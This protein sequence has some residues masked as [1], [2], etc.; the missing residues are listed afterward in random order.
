MT[1]RIRISALVLILASGPSPALAQ[2]RSFDVAS[3]K[4]NRS[5]ELMVR[6]DTEPGGRFVAVN[7][8]LRMLIQLAYGLNDFDIGGAPSWVASDHFDITAVTVQELPP[9]EGPTQGSLALQELLRSLLRDRFALVA[10]TEERERDGLALT[11]A[12]ADRRLGPRLKAS[13]TDCAAAMAANGGP[14]GCGL[15]MGPGQ[16]TLDGVPLAQRAQ[17]LTQMRGRPV[18]DR[19]NLGGP[20]DLQLKWDPPV[21]GGTPRP[22]AMSLTTALGD[23]AGLRLAS[24][25][26][27]GKVLIIDSVQQPTAN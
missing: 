21:P 18:V 15:Q 24:I 19:T 8:T 4:P 11:L 14:A 5:G 26:V 7:A 25:R 23:Q 12:N 16:I 2:Q 20:F 3:V 22:D 13:A 9:L 6:T 1:M 17:I 27:A 10:H